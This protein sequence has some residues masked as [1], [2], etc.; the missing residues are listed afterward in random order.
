MLGC[1]A[2]RAKVK[3]E[4][5]KPLKEV[6]VTVYFPDAE[7]NVIFEKSYTPVLATSGDYVSL[8]GGNN[9]PLKP[10]YIRSFGYVV[11]DCPSEC[12]PKKVQLAV[13]NVEFM[14]REL[15]SWRV[16]APSQMR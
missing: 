16:E 10:G 3:N 11:E 7:G 1:A 12:A 9:D 13:T 14:R 2:F 15:W 8:M 5:D 4:G 6:E